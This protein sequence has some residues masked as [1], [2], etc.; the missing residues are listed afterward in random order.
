M[1]WYDV[2]YT[3]G[4][5]KI[6]ERLDESDVDATDYVRALRAVRGERPDDERE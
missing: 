2:T 3:M 5:E 4:P 6:R 1:V